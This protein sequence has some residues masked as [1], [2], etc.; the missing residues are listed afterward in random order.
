MMTWPFL[1]VVIT[2]MGWIWAFVIP[3]VFALLW[4]VSWYFTV[5]DTPSEHK[6]ISDDECDYLRFRLGDGVKGAKVISLLQIFIQFYNNYNFLE[7]A[8]VSI[9]GEKSRFLCVT[10]GSIWQSVGIVFIA[11]SWSNVYER[12]S[13]LHITKIGNDGCYS[14]CGENDV[15]NNFWKHW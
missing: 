12:S 13:W 10:G 7:N 9:Y 15:W 1:G 4:S 3:G 11:K 14:I 6:F 5:A 8:I 2:S